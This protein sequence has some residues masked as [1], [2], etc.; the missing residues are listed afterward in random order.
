MNRIEEAIKEFRKYEA[1]MEKLFPGN[2]HGNRAFQ[3][4][5]LAAMERISANPGTNLSQEE[6]MALRVLRYEKRTMERRLFPNRMERVLRRVLVPT[7]LLV[8][9]LIKEA[10][11][12]VEIRKVERDLYES[13]MVMQSGFRKEGD[14]YVS[15]L[16]QADLAGGHR[17]EHQIIGVIQ[18][19]G[20]AA[21]EGVRATLIKPD[22]QKVQHFF[23]AESGR[24]YSN[25]EMIALLKGESVKV[26]GPSGRME[27]KLDFNDR[28][29][30]GSF[31]MKRVSPEPVLQSPT[32]G[33]SSQRIRSPRPQLNGK[34]SLGL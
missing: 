34:K 19:N 21:T 4:E 11:E 15:A 7:K 29:N 3:R 25:R 10:R 22:G 13:G 8:G 17:F 26:D 23:G 6:K 31:R 9:R 28:D 30:K 27:I 2:M 14:K 1:R 20:K 24:L 5:K 33:K 18:P 16:Q 32:I 12:R